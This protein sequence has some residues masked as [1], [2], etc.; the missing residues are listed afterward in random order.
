M[1][2]DE[3]DKKVAPLLGAI[4]IRADSVLSDIKQIEA[5]AEALPAVPEF[6]TQAMEK[7]LKIQTALW[8]S[9]V[10]MELARMKYKNKDTVS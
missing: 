9:I 10:M 6:E 3:W 4:S 1:S 5:W 7:M 8:A 2:L